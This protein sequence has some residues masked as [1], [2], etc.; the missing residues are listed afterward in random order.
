MTNEGVRILI[1]EDEPELLELLEAE[2][3]SAGF[4]TI[5]ATNGD[6]ALNKVVAEKPDLT[7][8]DIMM[9]VMDGY[10]FLRR[11]RFDH[12][13][14]DMMPVMFLT[15]KGETT[16]MMTALAL[17]V[18]DYITK[19]FDFDLL[20]A[21]VWSR[22]SQ[23]QR[24]AG[25]HDNQLVKVYRRLSEGGDVINDEDVTPDDLGASL[26]SIEVRDQT[27]G[28]PIVAICAAETSEREIVR[29][30]AEQAGMNVYESDSADKLMA[31]FPS[32]KP[33]ILFLSYRTSDIAGFYVANH[34]KGETGGVLPIIFLA[35][36]ETPFTEAMKLP[37]SFDDYLN[38]HE[39]DQR[40]VTLCEKWRNG[41][42]D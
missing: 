29:N 20:I 11:V 21:R 5:T 34:L 41:V 31:D 39:V 28:A 32:V 37:N 35:G 8:C 30:A 25:Y 19:P 26:A 17:G 36:E 33:A 24:I 18:D 42:G 4:G 22:I 10:E 40:F 6:E 7:L 23:L 38:T 15:A 27:P 12:P 2:L 16:D 1:V 9:P 13:E 3:S 14:L